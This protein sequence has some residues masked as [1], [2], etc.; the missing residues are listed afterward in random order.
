MRKILCFVHIEKAAG[1]SLIHILRRQFPLR[2]LDV[3]PYRFS[4]YAGRWN[5]VF[6]KGDLEVA[7]KINPFLRCIS[8]H[9]LCPQTNFLPIARMEYITLLRDPVDRYISQFYY[10]SE[11]RGK[12]WDFERFL[13]VEENTNFQVR[14]IAGRDDL[15]LAKKTIDEK[16]LAVGVVEKFDEFLSQLGAC[17]EGKALDTA[18][19]KAN[20]RSIST[21]EQELKDRFDSEIRA[22]NQLDI[23]L[24]QHCLERITASSG[25]REA[26]NS[27][28]SRSLGGT[29]GFGARLV[30]GADYLLRKC[31]YEPVT[32][33]VRRRNG[34]EAEGAY[35]IPLNFGEDKL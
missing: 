19:R 32:R 33:M 27:Q 9:A 30:D 12:Q 2:Y 15:E 21:G 8:T 17:I 6:D 31:Y 13:E 34:L 16:F 3:R 20:A 35:A 25:H 28:E 24:Y 1:T 18:Y 22:R 14:K 29:P 26:G 5:P 23:E 7:L 11:R 10:S 4:P